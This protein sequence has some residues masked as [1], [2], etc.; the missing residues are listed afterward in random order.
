MLRGEQVAPEPQPLPRRLA[1]DFGDHVDAPTVVLCPGCGSRELELRS[2]AGVRAAVAAF[3]VCR[4]CEELF[5]LELVAHEDGVVLGVY[6]PNETT[7]AQG[8]VRDRG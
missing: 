2:S 8:A 7:P 6:E 5:V 4:G 3:L 1:L